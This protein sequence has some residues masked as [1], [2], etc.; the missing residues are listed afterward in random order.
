MQETVGKLADRLA[1][2]EADLAPMPPS[3]DSRR[4]DAKKEP[5]Q[6]EK[7]S[8]RAL[9]A[10]EIDDLLIEPGAGFP[11]RL[12]SPRLPPSGGPA[13]QQGRRAAELAV[14]GNE[15]EPIVR[16]AGDVK[17]FLR[18]RGKPIFLGL[19][20]LC[21][22]LGAY[23]LARHRSPNHFDPAGFLKSIVIGAANDARPSER[24]SVIADDNAPASVGGITAS[25]DPARTAPP[26]GPNAPDV[27]LPRGCPSLTPR[28]VSPAD[29]GRAARRK[30]NHGPSRKREPSS[31][32]IGRQTGAQTPR[33]QG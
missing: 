6:G 21:L 24:R 3:R 22:M 20:A 33:R 10:A 11:P 4:G 9:A 25:A 5:S 19:A 29:R 26:A 14:I 28:L 8:P 16:E 13:E 31:N 1:R 2:V 30:P 12:P 27:I 15:R 23:A 7:R 32:G 18:G 17:G